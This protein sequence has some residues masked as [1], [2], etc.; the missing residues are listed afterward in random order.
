MQ[1]ST[2]QFH[3]YYYIKRLIM[4]APRG[5]LKIK[6]DAV[7]KLDKTASGRANRIKL[8]AR[9]AMSFKDNIGFVGDTLDISESGAMIITGY[10]P[11]GVSID[12]IGTI[13]LL[14]DKNAT[15]KISGKIVRVTEQGVA[16]TFC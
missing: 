3:Y 7:N 5:A 12:D 9:V 16:V 2:K 6:L 1:N 4:L 13:K 15:Q 10:R 14:H 8:D 11:L